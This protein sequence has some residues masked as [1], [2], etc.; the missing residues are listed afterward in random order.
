MY[1]DRT[2]E[3]TVLSSGGEK[4]EANGRK[5]ESDKGEKTSVPHQQTDAFRGVA[6]ERKGVAAWLMVQTHVDCAPPSEPKFGSTT[7]GIV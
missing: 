7:S 4:E 5:R 6:K 2:T 1:G 3:E